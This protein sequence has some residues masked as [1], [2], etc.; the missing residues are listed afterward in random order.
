M[1]N[2][3]QVQDDDRPMW[4]V[5]ESFEKALSDWRELIRREN[6]CDMPTDADG[7]DEFCRG[8][9]EEPYP[10]GIN[11][12]CEGADL[13]INGEIQP[14]VPREF[15]ATADGADFQEKR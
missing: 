13:M 6:P 8:T 14:S 1:P 2:L 15:I 4:A 9:H 7:H 11:F 3:Y 12:V 10:M 5:A